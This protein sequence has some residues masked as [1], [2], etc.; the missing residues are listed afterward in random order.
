MRF[1]IIVLSL[2]SIQFFAQKPTDSYVITY[3]KYYNDALMQEDF[4]TGVFTNAGTTVV[5][6]LQKPDQIKYPFTGMVVDR[7]TNVFKN[8]SWTNA[9]DK[10]GAI[11][12][13]YATKYEYHITDVTKKILGYTCKKATT[14]VNSNHYDIWFTN[15]IPTILGS[16]SALGQNLGLVLEVNRNN[17]FLIKAREIKTLKPSDFPFADFDKGVHYTDE[18]TYKDELWKSRFTTLEVF[19]AQTINFSEDLTA[20][21]PDVMR[22][23]HG[24][25]VVKK[26]KFPDIKK[27]SQIFLEM[28]QFSRGDAYDRTG[29]I[30]MIPVEKDS[31]FL[32]ALE[33]GLQ[34]LPVYRN[35]NGQDYQGVAVTPNYQPLIELMRFFTPFGIRQ[36]NY[37][38]LKDK[39]WMREVPYRQDITDFISYLNNKEVY[40]GAFIGNYDKNGHEVS[41]EITLHEESE[42][43][44]A[45]DWILPLFN[46]VNIME[47][48][49]Q[50]Y[51]SMF[52]HQ[53]G[54]TVN[55]HLD[56]EVKNV[57]LR[58]I[59]TGH[60]GWERGDEFLQ[61]INS[62]LLDGEEVFSFLPWRQD[63][64]SYRLY[65]PAS[66][67]FENGLSSSDYSRS[68]WCPGT[69]TNPE[70]IYLGDL[71]QGEHTLQVKINLGAREGNS[72]SAW[73]VS[74]CLM[75]DN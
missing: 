64:G 40:I 41:V 42:I 17:N 73:N 39:N 29:S 71:P 8:I 46:T 58:Y 61:K 67:N 52:D 4:P 37:L 68:N 6:S 35:G 54:L 1:L 44:K 48:S 31:T 74:G 30:F 38:Q 69:L 24:T 15:D 22:L 20:D 21:D 65:N 26:I 11:D 53:N 60:G 13:L 25:V 10:I 49:G 45:P 59:T 19:T 70:Y 33:K 66:G 18:L 62:I 34:E 12:S 57:R 36:Y 28:K 2:W 3:D 16:P 63:C 14:V 47:M 50:N 27:G 43:Q 72:F 23:S 55:F 32:K 75:G 7:K 5:V 9:S 56:K 51:G